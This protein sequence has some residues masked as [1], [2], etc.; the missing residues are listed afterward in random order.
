M[1][2]QQNGRWAK[3]YEEEKAKQ[4]AAPKPKPNYYYYYVGKNIK[5]LPPEE[6]VGMYFIVGKRPCWLI[7]ALQALVGI[8]WGE[9]GKIIGQIQTN[10]K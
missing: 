1:T 3:L 8:H 9:E 5:H 7:R 10:K 4:A 2:Q 6:R